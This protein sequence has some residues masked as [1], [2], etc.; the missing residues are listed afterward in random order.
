MKR[1]KELTQYV[2][3]KITDLK[4][5]ERRFRTVF[6]EILIWFLFEE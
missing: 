4:L 2:K 3:G 6:E 1:E 5:S